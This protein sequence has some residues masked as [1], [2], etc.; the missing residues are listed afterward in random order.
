PNFP[1]ATGRQKALLAT[2]IICT[3]LPSTAVILRISAQRLARRSLTAS[4][5]C[6]VASG[7]LA[8]GFQVATFIAIFRGGMGFGHEQRLIEGWGEEPVHELQKVVLSLELLWTLSM[9]LCK[10]SILL[11]YIKLFAGSYMV[12]V[13]KIT[14]GVMI[15]WP[16]ATVLGALLICTPV[17]QNWET[18]TSHHCGNQVAFYFTSGVINLTTDFFV[19]GLPLPHLYKLRLPRSSKIGLLVVFCLGLLTSIVSIVR[20]PYLLKIYWPDLTWT[21][22]YSNILTGIEPSMAVTLACVPM[23]KPLLSLG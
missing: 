13:S 20:L 4:D 21:I 3:I 12:V 23:L 8:V 17:Q 9:S 5:Y 22:A 1:I 2:A 6:I 18:L 7:F 10:T 15:L 14:I 11:L 16:I 19:V